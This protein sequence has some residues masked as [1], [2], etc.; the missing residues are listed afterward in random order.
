MKIVVDAMGGDFAPNNEVLGAIEAIKRDHSL[1]IIL[2]GKKEILEAEL[3]KHGH[4][5]NIQ[6]EQA[7]EVVSM[8]DSPTLVLKEK[9]D[10]SLS[11]GVKLLKD[12]KADAFV[13]C[14][15]TG[16]VLAA[17]MF[18][19]GRIKNVE[20]PAI[21]ALFPTLR[22]PLVILDIGANV[23]CKPK[24]LLQFAQM[25]T[26]FARKMLG[27][28]NPAVHLLNIGEESEKGNEL[29]LETYR[30]LSEAPGI[31]FL[32]N[33]EPKHLLDGQVDVVVCDGFVGNMILK[34]G[35]NVVSTL[36]KMMKDTVKKSFLATLGAILM[37]PTMKQLK[38]KVDYD[39]FGGTLLL[40]LKKVVI[41]AHGAASPKAVCNAILEAHHVKAQHV[42]E[43]IEA[44]LAATAQNALV[45]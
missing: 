24:H 37:F 6:I 34:F 2:V 3:A 10:S 12:S 22:D 45:E 36:F 20:R 21:V 26:V 43:D 42:V 41:I 4:P 5:K 16:A 14:G 31:K 33:I 8:H 28:E 13:S 19:L 9:K 32:G 44:M 25:G 23:D 38:K 1:E 15:N 30:L 18:A 11:V 39:E 17:S 29:T 35:E 7:S 27:K 40:G